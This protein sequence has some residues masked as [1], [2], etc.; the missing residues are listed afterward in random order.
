VDIA[1]WDEGYERLLMARKPGEKEYRFVGGFVTETTTYEANARREVQEETGIEITDPQY[2]CSYRVDDWRYRRERDGI[3]TILF[4]AKLMFG[5]PTPNDDIEELRWF[6]L[7]DIEQGMLVEEHWPLFER[8]MKK[9][10][11]RRN[12]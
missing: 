5:T 9:V 7:E 2:V 4:E 3:V 6:K 12:S 10:E 1:I 11:T 8:L